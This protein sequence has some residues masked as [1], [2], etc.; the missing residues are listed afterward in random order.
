MNVSEL[1]K[2]GIPEKI[3]HDLSIKGFKE[4]TRVQEQAVQSGL[5]SGNSF[6]VPLLILVRLTLQN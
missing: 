1:I 3:I 4:L 6:L 5:F 2:Y